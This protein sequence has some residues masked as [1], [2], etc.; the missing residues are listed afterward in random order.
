MDDRTIIIFLILAAML[1]GVYLIGRSVEKAQKECQGWCV[2][3]TFTSTFMI[4]NNS[5]FCMTPTGKWVE[6]IMGGG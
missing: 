1:V 2:N 5:C 3:N 6:R 4:K